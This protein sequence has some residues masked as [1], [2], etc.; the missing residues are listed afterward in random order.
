M[1]LRTVR[2]SLETF[3]LLLCSTIFT[4]CWS[5]TPQSTNA[6]FREA[7]GET[8]HVIVLRNAEYAIPEHLAANVQ[9]AAS[10]PSEE[11]RGLRLSFRSLSYL[12]SDFE[13]RGWIGP[14]SK[15]ADKGGKRHVFFLVGVGQ[16]PEP[17]DA[18]KARAIIEGVGG[19]VQVV[20]SP[21]G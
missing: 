2:A 21:K 8:W 9:R 15:S 11:W 10:G 19:I 5:E 16:E 17:L 20:R 1:V 14:S 6:F 12:I 4:G 18:A 7:M 13:K 3:V